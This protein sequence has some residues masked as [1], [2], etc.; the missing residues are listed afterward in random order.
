MNK[1]GGDPRSLL[2]SYCETAALII[3]ACLYSFFPFLLPLTLQAPTR[4]SLRLP[5][6]LPARS[7][8]PSRDPTRDRP[9]LAAAEPAAAAARP[10]GCAPAGN[11]R[12][13]CPP[14]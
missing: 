10:P 8:T 14:E 11:T 4:S 5:A 12:S 7:S 2:H 13:R 6:L 9:R 1:K 3:V